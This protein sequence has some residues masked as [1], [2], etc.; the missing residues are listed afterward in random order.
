MASKI[1]V[2]LESGRTEWSSAVTECLIAC[3]SMKIGST[4]PIIATIEKVEAGTIPAEIS[5][6]R[7]NGEFR[8]SGGEA[9]PS[10]KV[11]VNWLVFSEE[12]V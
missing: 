12:E 1:L 8:L 2:P 6:L 11:F 4:N 10:K 5:V 3:P 9:K 7:Q